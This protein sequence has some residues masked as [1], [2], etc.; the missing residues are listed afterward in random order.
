M[1]RVLAL[2]L[3]LAML[4][5]SLALAEE[6]VTA[7]A[8]YDY[9]ELTVGTVMPMYGSF[10]LD[11]WGNSSSDVDVRKLINGYNLVEWNTE[12]GG[13]RLDPSVVTN[14]SVVTR[15]DAGNHIYNI[16]LYE[17]LYYSDGTPITAW[18]YA[19]SWLLRTSPLLDQIGGKSLDADF[20]VGW[21]DYESG[22]TPY[23]TGLR[24]IGKYQL[25]IRIRAEYLPYFY[26]VGLLDCYPWPIHVI[27][28]GCEV[29]DDGY[30]AYIRNREEPRDVPLFTADLL[31]RTLLDDSDGY[32]THPVAVSGPYRIV[33][34]DGEEARF[35]LNPYYKGNSENVKPLI[36]RI[37]FRVAS[38]DTMIDEMMQGKYGLLNKV[39]RGDVIRNGMNRAVST[40]AYAMS[41]YPRQGLS[42]ITFN[43]TRPATAEPEVRKAI[44]LCL[45]K[46]TLTRDYVGEYGLQADGFYGLGQW[47][48]QMAMGTLRPESEE[49]ETD[50]ETEQTEDGWD[51]ITLE[52]IE[53]YAFDTARAEE[54][55][56][57]AGW[58][59]N[60]DGEDYLSGMDDVRC[61][62][63]D[64]TLVPLELKLVY[65]ETTQIAKGF[66]TCFAAHLKDVGILLKT[67]KSGS[68]L[69]MYYGQ[70]EPDYDMLF[71][72]TNFDIDF[73]PT[74]LFTE[75]GAVNV[76]GVKSRSL[77]EAAEDMRKTESGDL[78]T[79]CQ[80]WIEYQKRFA[81]VEPMIPVYS[82]AYYDFYPQVLRK[83][84]ITQSI[85]WSEAVIGS[86]FSDVP[87]AEEVPAEEGQEPA[88]EEQ[89]PAEETATT[90]P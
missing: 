88:E 35:E 39:S 25:Q 51:E 46:E 43:G 62:E 76:N 67:E 41:T 3:M 50:A 70:Q 63:I 53:T 58:T 19:F 22:K 71:L 17:D 66:E 89:E 6:T 15:D 28:P 4:M 82:N 10:T 12:L 61:K 13:F 24:V 77:T 55:L 1:K 7:T 31:E 64:G 32:L 21:E 74:P 57:E 23:L 60:R 78:L 37:N 87:P 38:A 73:D 65:P 56:D 16:T 9:D 29:R 81:D 47:M 59:L 49:D 40:G 48:Y 69:A 54:I 27:A 44:A 72:G 84:Q 83:Y 85:T 79:Y 2:L 33:H 68:V 42:F 11:S 5:G 75:G 26:E 90:A 36:P 18:D 45:D 8:A 86:Y 52:G 34:F 30:G 80:K 20:L 14:G